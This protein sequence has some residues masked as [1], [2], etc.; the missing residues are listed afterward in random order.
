MCDVLCVHLGFLLTTDIVETR[1][2]ACERDAL[3]KSH[4]SS[5]LKIAYID[6]PICH[7]VESE[8]V[9]VEVLGIGDKLVD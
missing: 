7:S 5:R 4:H 1:T 6:N 2:K 8:G 9:G 3:S